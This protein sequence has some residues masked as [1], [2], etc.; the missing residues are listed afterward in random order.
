MAAPISHR[1]LMF[2]ASAKEPFS[3]PGWIYELKHDG[4]RVLVVKQGSEVQLITLHG[5]DLAKAFP[6]L[7]VEAELLPNAVLDGELVLVD[8][9]GKPQ[10]ESLCRRA[11]MTRLPLRGAGAPDAATIFAFDLLQLAGEDLRPL[12]LIKR[13]AILQKVLWGS[14]GIR[15]LQHIDEEGEALYRSIAEAGLEGMVAK[16]A[17]APYR[18]G[19][20]GYWLKVKTPAFKEIERRRLATAELERTKVD[21]AI[22]GCH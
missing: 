21:P 13:K 9:H 17:T 4:F 19:R 1:D 14:V 6:E 2:A 16:R 11:R 18:A 15:Y 8:E 5:T 12:P 10:F 20:S 7:V 22:G 3:R